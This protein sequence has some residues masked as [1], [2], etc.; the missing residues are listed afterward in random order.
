MLKALVIST[1]WKENITING[2]LFDVAGKD[3]NYYLSSDEEKKLQDWLGA[4]DCST[5]YSTV[6]NNRVDG[7][8][9]WIFKDPTYLK[10][11]EEGSILWIQGQAGSGK[12][13][14]ITSI[15][16][17][18]QATSVST[19]TIYHYFDTRD[20]TGSKTSFQGLLASFLSQLGTQDQRIHPELKNLHE[21]SKSGLTHC[22]PTNQKLADT[23]IKI[24][25]ELVQK[26]YQVYM[27]IDAL[28]EAKEIDKVWDFC[29]Q[30]NSLQSIW[31]IISS[32]KYQ[33]ET[34]EYF[35]LSLRN[36]IMVDK[37]IAT[38]LN[39]QVSLKST[40]LNT[41]VKATLMQK[42]DG[43]FRYIDCQVQIL[44]QSANARKVREALTKLPAS[45]EV[46]Y[47]DEFHKSFNWIAHNIP[48]FK[49]T[50]ADHTT[51]ARN[52][53]IAKEHGY[54]YKPLRQAHNKA[55]SEEE[56]QLA[57][58]DIEEGRVKDGADLQRRRFPEI[59]Q[60]T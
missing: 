59:P 39:E 27:I 60:R 49:N 45:L 5:N 24:T 9:Q 2:G 44:K 21:S 41:E 20:N 12:T 3:I 52:Y 54:Y 56:A 22:K 30:M 55:I 38:F 42:A 8:G 48:E 10:W 32:R 57:I 34:S 43:G 11:K 14:L 19:L 46:L 23:L 7:T 50:A 35:T 29:V 51:I 28:D 26:K 6:L 18:F 47:H 16:E 4:P 1:S 58:A 25:R 13:F 36:N 40:T 53:R 15:I 31:I 37:D 33:P 17:D